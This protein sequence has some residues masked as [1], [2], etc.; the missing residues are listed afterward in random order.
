MM[1]NTLRHHFGTIRWKLA[2][3]YVLVALMIAL[4]GALIVMAGLLLLFNS[5]VLPNAFADRTNRFASALRPDYEE[6]QGR[7]KL[8]SAHLKTLLAQE[9][10]QPEGLDDTSAPGR[11]NLGTTSADIITV[12]VDRDGRVLAAIPSVGHPAGKRLIDL[13][14]PDVWLFPARALSGITETGQLAG[15]AGSSELVAVAPVL[16]RDQHVLGAVFTRSETL[17]LSDILGS[18]ALSMLLFIVP[19]LIVSSLIGLVYGW[20]AGRGFSRRLVRLTEA[21]AALAAGDLSWRV[22]DRSVDEIGQLGRQFNLMAD[23]LGENLRV[24]RLLADQNAQLA[25]RATQLATIEERNR[26]ARDLHDS[27]SQELFSL[28]MLAA[29]ARRVIDKKPA[30]ATAHVEEIQATAQRALQETRSLIFALRPAALDDRGLGPALRDLAAAATER[31]GMCID[32]SISGERRLP[33][34]HEQ[35]LFRIVQEALAN[36]ARHSGERAAQVALC[37]A[38]DH[39][40]LTVSDRGHGFDCRAPRGAGSIGLESMAERAGALGGTLSIDSTPGRGTVITVRLPTS[41]KITK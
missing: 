19:V 29:A 11:I 26:L 1:L 12:L 28:S 4:L 39:V 20:F 18:I 22:D 15:W 8:L 21:N 23:Q 3:S 2:G 9:A 10:Q 40:D 25:E 24:L 32:L 31:Q 41:D 33:L 34:E 30:A 16:S 35:A 13:E 27:I 6:A 36:V 7:E 14:P 37:C 38:D 17:P 5:R